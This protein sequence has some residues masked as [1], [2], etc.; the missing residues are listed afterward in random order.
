MIHT[1]RIFFFPCMLRGLRCLRRNWICKCHLEWSLGEE[2]ITREVN[3]LKGDDDERSKLVA[4]IG[5]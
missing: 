4:Q 5:E 2:N 1:D 3:D